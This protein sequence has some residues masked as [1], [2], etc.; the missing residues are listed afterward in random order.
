MSSCCRTCVHRNDAVTS[1]STT[2]SQLDVCLI[3]LTFKRR[4]QPG[5]EPYIALN[6]V[7]NNIIDDAESTLRPTTFTSWSPCL[8]HPATIVV[9]TTAS[10]TCSDPESSIFQNIR[11]YLAI[12]PKTR[13]IYLPCS[14]LSLSASS[15][16]TRIPCDII[17]LQAPTPAVAVTIGKHFG[18][19]PQRSSLSAQMQSCASA[20][21]STP[22][23]L[24]RDFWV[25]AEL[26]SEEPMSPSTSTS[27]SI[28]TG[29][30]ESLGKQ[31]Q[32][33][34]S[35]EKNMSLRFSEDEDELPEV[36]DET[37]VMVFQWNTHADG[38]RFKHPLQKS[39]GPNGVQVSSDLWDRS[40]AHP[41]RQLRNLGVRNEM[42]RLEFRAVEP[43]IDCKRDGKKA[44]AVRER[45]GS[46][47]LSVIAS[48]LGERVSG[49]W[50]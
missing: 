22:G 18:W 11:D 27:Y 26:R 44:V 3:T 28:A 16:E 23:D 21:F 39:L 41:V 49:L 47:R 40:V 25:W 12:P 30:S 6:T 33:T 42:Y 45:S 35:D 14:I 43:R 8:S 10:K 48:E 4:I 1:S 13:N 50:R 36:E 20:A 7:L 34:N 9:V 38:D 37:L 15:P 24:I 5:S 46:R 19:D 31:L 29:S 17:A 2:Q 32:S